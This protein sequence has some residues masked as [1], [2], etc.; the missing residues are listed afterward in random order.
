VAALFFPANETLRGIE[1]AHLK[2]RTVKANLSTF[3]ARPI[4][5]MVRRGLKKERKIKEKT[6]LHVYMRIRCQF[7]KILKGQCILFVCAII[8]YLFV[9]EVKFSLDIIFD[10]LIFEKDFENWLFR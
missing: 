7:C 5:D 4:R 6:L 9:L 1:H 2:K 3:W 8:F 10:F